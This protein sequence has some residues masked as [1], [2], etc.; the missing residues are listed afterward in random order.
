MHLEDEDGRSLAEPVRARL[1]LRVGKGVP[2]G[3]GEEDRVGGLLI[4]GWAGREGERMLGGGN[5][6][7]K[8]MQ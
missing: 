1:G 6:G 7:M 8:A 2:V 4:D 3:V 5:K